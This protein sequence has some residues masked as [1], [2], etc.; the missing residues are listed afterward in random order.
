MIAARATFR[1]RFITD[2]R[3]LLW[4][5]VVILD[6]ATAYTDPENEADGLAEAEHAHQAESS[7]WIGNAVTS[8][9]AIGRL[10]WQR[11]L[12][13]LSAVHAALSADRV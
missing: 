8:L 12:E 2:V 7:L 10:P 1:V 11:V 13:S 6:E 3:R 5:V 4:S 9:R